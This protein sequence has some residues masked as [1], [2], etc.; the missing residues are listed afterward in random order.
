MVVFLTDYI[1]IDRKINK[2]ICKTCEN[3]IHGYSKDSYTDYFKR[4]NI[5]L[6]DLI[7]NNYLRKVEKIDYKNDSISN[8]EIDRVIS[9][10]T[11]EQVKIIAYNNSNI[12]LMNI[13]LGNILLLI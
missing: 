2:C 1:I 6:L 8:I 5:S 13:I 9:D 12:V 11:K 3:D 4:D 10:N 7:Q